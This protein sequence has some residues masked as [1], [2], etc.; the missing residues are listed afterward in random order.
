M[1]NNNVADISAFESIQSEQHI[2]TGMSSMSVFN[3]LNKVKDLAVKYKSTVDS[4]IASHIPKAKAVYDEYQAAIKK[5]GELQSEDPLVKKMQDMK[6]EERRKRKE[7]LSI[8]EPLMK[9]IGKERRA[10]N[11]SLDAEEPDSYERKEK[12]NVVIDEVNRVQR[13]VKEA[14][15]RTD[16]W[17]GLHSG[18]VKI[19]SYFRTP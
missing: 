5:H 7:L 18:S 17:F 4:Y 1:P 16:S 19:E 3:D 14:V 15:Q 2:K 12:T 10:V 8:A 9:E 6:E 11:K 13:Q